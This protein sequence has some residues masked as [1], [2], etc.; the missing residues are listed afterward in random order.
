MTSETVKP[1][2]KIVDLH[3]EAFRSLRNVAWPAD[4][5][6]WG[7]TIPE[8]VIVGGVNGSGKTT[9]LELI[10]EAVQGLFVHGHRDGKTVPTT[11]TCIQFEL[12]CA[13]MADAVFTWAKGMSAA[14]KRNERFGTTIRYRQDTAS[15]FISKEKTTI[16]L[17][18]LLSTIAD[19]AAFTASDIPGVVYLPTDRRFD[20]PPETYKAPGK[21]AAND[22]FFH[23]FSAPVQWRDSL[24]ALLYS[25]RWAD[26]NAKDEG[27]P[28][29]AIHFESYAHA[30]RAFFGDAKSLV[31]ENGELFVK[32]LDAGALHPLMDLSSG[33]KQALILAAELYRRWRPG[34]LI[35][36]D[37]PELHFHTSWQTVLY[38]MLERWQRERGGQVVIATQSNHLFRI[39]PPETTVL[40]KGPL[41]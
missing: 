15:A 9:L 28:E 11:P 26:L 37:E 25:A 4:G 16:P 2:L 23:R 40:L 17:N 21:L 20:I 7:D 13:S 1:S 3:V 38:T 27:H 36:I 33:E 32:I 35:L 31:W 22:T 39:A 12:Q 34:S 18:D 8:M 5:L 10:A 24:E 19:P 30:F 6:G 14:R 29:R 41:A